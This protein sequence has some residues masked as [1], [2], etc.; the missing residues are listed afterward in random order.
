MNALLNLDDHEDA[1][2]HF[3]K[4]TEMK[5]HHHI[6]NSCSQEHWHILHLHSQHSSSE[7]GTNDALTTTRLF[8]ATLHVYNYGHATMSVHWI[9]TYIFEFNSKDT[10]DSRGTTIDPNLTQSKINHKR[11]KQK[12]YLLN[13]KKYFNFLTFLYWPPLMHR[14]ILKVHILGDY[15]WIEGM[16]PLPFQNQYNHH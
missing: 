16:A 14:I 6:Y 7:H 2:T 15:L 11:Y 5:S 3:Y 1:H 13:L 12:K 8:R 10:D 9:Y 4:N